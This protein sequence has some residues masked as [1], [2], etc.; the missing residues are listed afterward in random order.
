MLIKSI[1]VAMLILVSWNSYKQSESNALL[2]KQLNAL[3]ST[4]ETMAKQILS[5]QDMFK[6]QNMLL[7]KMKKNSKKLTG[8]NA[9]APL[10][11]SINKISDT[12]LNQANK[13][14]FV[15]DELKR[16]NSNNELITNQLL[17]NKKLYLK[18]VKAQGGK[19]NKTQNY[20]GDFKK[21]FNENKKLAKDNK[22]ALVPIKK[23]VDE[24]NSIVKEHSKILKKN[25]NYLASLSFANKR[26]NAQKWG[27]D[28]NKNFNKPVKHKPKQQQLTSPN[29]KPKVQATKAVKPVYKPKKTNNRKEFE[30]AVIQ[31]AKLKT[32]EWKY[33]NDEN[34]TKD[35]VISALS[36]ITT[37]KHKKVDKDG[38]IDL[39]E[40]YKKAIIPIR[41]SINEISTLIKKQSKILEKD[42]KRYKPKKTKKLKVALK[43][44]TTTSKQYSKPSKLLL[45][46]DKIKN[47]GNKNESSKALSQL[48]SLKSQVWKCRHNDNVSN[49][50]I[51]STFSSIDI[52]KKQM[53]A[54]N[55]NYNLGNVEEKI[56]QLSSISG[57]CE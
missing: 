49:D 34:A 46:L 18:S 44:E 5:N 6:K 43:K 30:D 14:K 11:K 12:V 48:E 26:A 15:L 4:N 1:L 57:D 9:L 20:T 27:K 19:S 13:N 31:L 35:L 45:E 3:S 25:A 22:N 56:I 21:L 33:R 55:K 51:L 42:Y 47:F 32:E 54:K 37:T 40:E 10:K 24:I 16:I 53:E 7:D 17:N 39:S 38:N 2:N 23:S 41:N 36:S 28:N 8:Q 50:L 52:I 29:N